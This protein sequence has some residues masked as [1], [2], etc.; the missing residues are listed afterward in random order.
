MDRGLVAALAR[1]GADLPALAARA[2][3][4]PETVAEL[5]AGLAA[6]SAS[7]KYGCEKVLRRVSEQRPDL[8]LPHCD[9]FVKLLRSDNSFLKWGA[10]I[11]LGNLAPAARDGRLERLFAQYFAPIT[12]PVLVTAANTMKSAPKIARAKPELLPRVVRAILKVEKATF[13]HRGA[14]SPECRNVACGHALAALDAIFA[15]SEPP[16]PVL[17]FARRQLESTRASVRKSAQRFVKRHAQAAEAL[18]KSGE[19]DAVRKAQRGDGL[20]APG[21]RRRGPR[22]RR[23]AGRSP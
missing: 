5:V 17:A 7:V 19:K 18:P 6:P 12:G 2:I 10:I 20:R 22:A 14:P 1:K 11:T 4:R 9:V 23:R 15:E 16:P 13:Y 8:L 21:E 3:R